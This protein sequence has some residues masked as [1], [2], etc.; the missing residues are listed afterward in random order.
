[1]KKILV[2][3]FEKVYFEDL[4]SDAYENNDKLVFIYDLRNTK[5]LSLSSLLKDA[6][7]II[8]RYEEIS[9]EKLVKNIVIAPRTWQKILVKAL[10][11]IGDT[12]KPC[13]IYDDI[14]L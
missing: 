14:N 8:E 9:K 2:N 13:E 6:R 5:E 11:K 12:E 3:N 4:V 1:M 7:P 10:L